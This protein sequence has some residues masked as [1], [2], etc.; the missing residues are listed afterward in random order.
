MVRSNFWW[1]IWSLYVRLTYIPGK[2]DRIE[3]FLRKRAVKT[4]T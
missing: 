2:E 4:K 1:Y 3:R